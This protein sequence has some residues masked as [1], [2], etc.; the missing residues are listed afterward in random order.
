MTLAEQILNFLHYLKIDAPVPRGVHVLNPYQQP[1]VFD[2]CKQFYSKYYADNESRTM[3]IG[4]NPGRLGAGL[5][6]VPFTDPIRLKEICKI[7]NTLPAK[8][9]LS[10]D[11]IYRMIDSFGGVHAFY[12]KF[13][14]SSVSPLGFTLKGKNLNYYDVPLL[15]KR[16]KPFMQT[17]MRTQLSWGLN[18]R[19][20]FCLGEGE[21]FKFLTAWN[22]EEKF[23]QEIIS[24]PHPRFIMQYK[25][26]QL[27]NYLHLY[28]EKLKQF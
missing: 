13:Y 3:L 20:A 23:F 27:D 10:S 12:Q 6:G 14:F 9:E 4:I 5:T 15:Q 2:L 11:F 17:C 24:L 22:K 16:L 18:T 1:A 25:R 26:R 21:N 28:V 19:V 8:P 7:E